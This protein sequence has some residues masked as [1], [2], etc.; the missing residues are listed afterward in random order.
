MLAELFLGAGLLC[1]L[2]SYR[3]HSAFDPATPS[4]GPPTTSRCPTP[5]P[6]MLH[7][8]TSRR[9][10]R[11]FYQ[12]PGDSRS[13]R[14]AGVSEL[15]SNPVILASHTH[16]PY[17]AF[18]SRTLLFL[19]ES[20]VAGFPWATKAAILRETPNLHPF[21]STIQIRLMT[22]PPSIPRETGPSGSANYIT[23]TC[24]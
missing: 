23:S 8:S 2:T 11:S 14:V 24:A 17:G 3:L 9:P 20:D 4:I 1:A 22:W 5:I 19:T 13:P 15:P 7:S 16:D 18:L 21:S 10:N 12:G 6:T